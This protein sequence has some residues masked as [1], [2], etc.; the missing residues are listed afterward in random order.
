MG[1][2]KFLFLFFQRFYC[3]RVFIHFLHDLHLYVRI[4]VLNCYT[5]KDIRAIW[6]PNYLNTPYR[7]PHVFYHKKFAF[8]RGSLPVERYHQCGFAY[9]YAHLSHH[10]P[11][12]KQSTQ[13]WSLQDK[14]RDCKAK[15]SLPEHCVQLFSIQFKDFSTPIISL[16]YAI[17]AYHK[18]TIHNL[19]I[20]TVTKILDSYQ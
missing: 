6:N 16:W 1:F 14:E 17:K 11:K 3:W 12:M 2:P 8:R 20:N 19:N 5:K 13:R 18:P 10:E 7:Q 9:D 4:Y 15:D